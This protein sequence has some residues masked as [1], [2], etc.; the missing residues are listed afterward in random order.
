MRKIVIF[1]SVCFE[2]DRISNNMKDKKKITDIAT[3]GNLV[4]LSESSELKHP[5]RGQLAER[6]TRPKFTL[7]YVEYKSMKMT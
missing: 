1:S 3:G 2:P 4:K 7:A 5:W 6:A